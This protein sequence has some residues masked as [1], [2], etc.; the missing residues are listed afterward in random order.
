MRRSQEGGCQLC[1]GFLREGDNNA[2]GVLGGHIIIG[3]HRE[4]EGTL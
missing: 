4:E 3:L 1:P 2:A